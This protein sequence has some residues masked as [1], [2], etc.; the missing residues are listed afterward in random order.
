MKEFILS[1][2]K[3]GAAASCSSAELCTAGDDLT[4]TVTGKYAMFHFP[5]FL[6]ILYFN[7]GG[8]LKKTAQPQRI[9]Q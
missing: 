1:I 9:W 2:H 3:P 5:A 8:R 4:I 7:N 6:K